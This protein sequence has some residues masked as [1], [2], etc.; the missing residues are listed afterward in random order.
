MN[1]KG[2][3]ETIC[4]EQ[5]RADDTNEPVHFVM[6]SDIGVMAQGFIY[7]DGGISMNLMTGGVYI[8]LFFNEL[9]VEGEYIYLYFYETEGITHYV[10]MIACAE[11]TAFEVD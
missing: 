2:M 7:P 5:M 11:I 8:R 9:R 6:E 3:Y 4:Y 10:G 1:A